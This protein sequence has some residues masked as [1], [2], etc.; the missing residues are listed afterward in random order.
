MY[1]MTLATED[2]Q[3][4]YYQSIRRPHHAVF[5]NDEY[6][7][8]NLNPFPRRYRDYGNVT[9]AF[10]NNNDDNNNNDNDNSNNPNDNNDNNDNN[11][12]LT[13]QDRT[14]DRTSDDTTNGLQKRA[15]LSLSRAFLFRVRR[16]RAIAGLVG[17]VGWFGMYYL[18]F[19]DGMGWHGM[20]WDGMEWG[21]SGSGVHFWG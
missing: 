19:W 8:P 7:H 9:R 1:N 6:S 21:F 10:D 11:H 2:A 16:L 20:G 14:R 12:H 4:N 15:F 18:F 17:G 3:N 13:T 5:E